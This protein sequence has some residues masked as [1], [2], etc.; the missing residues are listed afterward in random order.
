[1]WQYFSFTHVYSFLL[2]CLFLDT[3]LRKVIESGEVMTS[4]MSEWQGKIMAI[5][6]SVG[7]KL[8][9]DPIAKGKP[10]FGTFLPA[11]FI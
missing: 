7:I 5:V 1:M 8:S 3:K 2:H 9:R 4:T 6:L 10:R 11:N